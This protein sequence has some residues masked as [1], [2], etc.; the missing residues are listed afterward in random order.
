MRRHPFCRWACLLI[1]VGVAVVLGCKGQPSPPSPATPV[2]PPAPPK[3]AGP[4]A[5]LPGQAGGELT[6]R[7][8]GHS[9]FTVTGSD[10]TVVVTDPYKGTGYSEEPVAGDVVT[11]S[12]EH[13]D[14]NNTALVSGN[15]EIVKGVGDH[16]AKG[17]TITG[18]AAYH[19]AEQ[20]KKRGAD[21][22]M[23]WEQDGIRLVHLGDLGHL[24][25]DDEIQKIGK[26]DV[27]FIP[28]GGFFTIDAQEA[29]QVVEQLKPKIVVPMH[30]RTDALVKQLADKLA[31]V[32][33]FLK[34][35]QYEEKDVLTLTKDALPEQTTYYKLSY[36]K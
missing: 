31:P 5:Q 2:S 34:G 10:A 6:I 3:P 17:L 27:L 11:I 36:R 23:V 18:V 15:P 35:K 24:L 32:D 12:H 1:V 4:T 30:Y 8:I 26:V 21:T 14:H 19:D 25:T 29:D 33:D 7:W 13:S 28:V 20:G 22:I 16:T 9:C